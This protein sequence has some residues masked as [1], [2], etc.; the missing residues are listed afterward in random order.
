MKTPAIQSVTFRFV[1]IGIVALSMLIPLLFVENIVDERYYYYNSVVEEIGNLWGR[2]QH[3]QGPFLLV[4]FVEKLITQEE[5]ALE[6][7]ATKQKSRTQFRNRTAVFL[8]QTLELDIRMTEHYRDRAIYRSLVYA[9]E[10]SIAGR[11]ARP[12]F[13]STLNNLHAIHWHKARLVVG[14]TDTKAIDEVLEL[15]WNGEP[16]ILAAGGAMQPILHS[17]FHVPLDLSDPSTTVYQLRAELRLNGSGGIRFAPLGEVT[18]AT[19]ASS[20]PHP[21]FAGNLLPDSRTITDDGFS[22]TWD[23]PHLARNYPQSWVLEDNAVNTT[24][25]LAGVD[26]FEPVFIYSRIT[27]AVKYGLLVVALTFLTFLV[28][29]F[30]SG[31]SL[32]TIQYGLVGIAL[33]IFYLLLLSLAEH[34]GFNLAYL[35]AAG[36][37]IM[38][39]S[40][41][42]AS[43]AGSPRHG[44]ILFSLLGALFALLYTLLKMEDYALLAGSVSLFA[45]LAILMF[46]TRRLRVA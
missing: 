26:L 10:L 1:L 34:I 18:H 7:G 23:I 28:F 21:S 40:R 6:N 4:P 5:I 32:H 30:A 13:A 24:E 31:I 8:P 19:L 25:L 22:A 46:L 39:I 17:G 29:E 42:V 3:I 2:R 15:Q 14:L 12:D 37:S 33:A 16:Q 43:A 44:W 9:A 11:F 27:R 35:V 38:L 45:V 36:A 20:W 41:Y